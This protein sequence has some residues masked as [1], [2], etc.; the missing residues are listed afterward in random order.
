[1]WHYNYNGQYSVKS[2][3]K[4][5]ISSHSQPLLTLS[6]G[7]GKM[8]WALRVPGKM[9]IFLWNA[10]HNIQPTW[11]NLQMRGMV[12]PECCLFCKAVETVDHILFT[13]PFVVTCW[14][15]VDF[16]PS[17]SSITSLENFCHTMLHNSSMEIMTKCCALL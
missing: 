14:R 5:F 15:I 4:V 9:K 7:V 1:M 11:D 3:Y 10:F 17:L 6:D 12:V 16:V 13:C 2:S 8:I